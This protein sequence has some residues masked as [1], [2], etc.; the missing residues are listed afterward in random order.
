[1]CPMSFVVALIVL[2]L[3]VAVV[4]RLMSDVAFRFFV[5]FILVFVFLVLIFCVPYVLFLFWS[6]RFLIVTR[7][8]FPPVI[9]LIDIIG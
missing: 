2:I 4:G 7:L 9:I 3:I 1:M 8:L 5:V 6:V